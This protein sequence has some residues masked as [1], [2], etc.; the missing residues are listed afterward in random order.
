MS[1]YKKVLVFANGTNN[2]ARVEADLLEL[3]GL[4]A[5]GIS[6]A[7]DNL[8]GADRVGMKNSRTAMPAMMATMMIVFTSVIAV[9]CLLVIRFR[10]KNSIE[11]D[12]PKIGSL[13]SIGYTSRQIALSVVAQYGLVACAACLAGVIP[14]YPVLPFV[15]DVFAQQSGLHWV[16][17]FEPLVNIA[18]VGVLTLIVVAVA[19]LAALKIRKISPVRALRGGIMT[20]SFKHNRIPLEKWRMPLTAALSLKSILQGLRQSVMMFVILTAVSFTAIIAVILYYNAAVDLSTFEK[21][22]GIERANAALVFLPGEDAEAMRAEVADHKDVWKAQYVDSGRAR[23]DDVDAGAMVMSDFSGKETVNVYKGIFPRFDNEIAIAGLL[24]NMIG[25]GIGDEVLVGKEER[26]YLITGLTQ[27]MEAGSLTV[28]LTLDGMRK[29]TPGFRQSQLMIYLN[30]GVSA[31]AF[32]DEMEAVYEGRLAT[33]VDA[34]ASFAEGVSS[35]ASIMSLVG[36]AIVIVAGFVIVL[37]L[38]F[39]I[40]SAII[41]RRRELGIQKAI[42]FTTANLMNQISLGFALPLTLGAL[43]GCVLGMVATNPL[44]SIGMSPLGVM[45][46]NYLINTAWVVATGCCVVVLSYLTSMFI[47]WRIRK[48]SAYALVTE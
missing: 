1:D 24:A 4:S 45:K 30:N 40:G 9:V 18:S 39:V 16:S 33:C 22:P 12:M 3:T 6:S 26:P 25:K 23:V 13:Q 29:I 2:Y 37:V 43:A 8:Y 17:G 36:L 20:H 28:Y 14:V 34:D 48:I 32:V 19:L 47:T 35:Y 46:A 5:T 38:Y 10:I 44:M 27:G 15:G 11:E 7:K 31:A 42:G 21:V 41:R